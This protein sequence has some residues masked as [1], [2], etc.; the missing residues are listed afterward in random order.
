MD[1]HPKGK[2]PGRIQDQDLDALLREAYARALGGPLT[3]ELR[4]LLD[5]IEK[6]EDDGRLPKKTRRPR[7]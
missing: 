7:K 2:K 6:A 4:S 5:R 3:P 1:N